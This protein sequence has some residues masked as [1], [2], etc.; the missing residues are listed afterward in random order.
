MKN[1]HNT[2]DPHNRFAAGASAFGIALLVVAVLF[3]TCLVSG[4]SALAGYRPVVP[5]LAT[6]NVVARV[7]SPIERIEWRTNTVT[8][9]NVLPG[10]VLVVTNA[11][12][13]AP[14]IVFTN[15]VL[16]VTNQ[17][18]VTNGYAV[19]P[20]FEAA[21]ENGRRLNSALNP[22]PTAPLVDWGL[23]LATVAAGAVAA[24]K[25]RSA[26]KAEIVRDTLIK[27]VETAPPAVV[28]SLKK[29]VA[30]VADLRDVSGDLDNAVQK[31]TAAMADGRMTAEEFW[32]LANDPAVTE[33]M[34]PE[35]M[36]PAFRKFRA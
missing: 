12:A 15:E 27:A 22:T 9:T 13:V 3:L 7:L 32:A 18:V 35:P 17:V 16:L 4:C 34:I 23:S 25:T 33:D 20:Q 30:A 11:Q 10:E 5:S 29:H 21:V 1:R 31:V 28:S 19:N 2:F 24:W 36:R 14:V 8:V 6:N 26:K